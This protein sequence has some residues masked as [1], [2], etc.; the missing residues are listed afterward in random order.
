MKNLV[1]AST[2][3]LL[4]S[5]LVFQVEKRKEEGGQDPPAV[6]LLRSGT[7]LREV[8]GGILSD[9][10]VGECLPAYFVD[11]GCPACRELVAQWDAAGRPRSLWVVA[12]LAPT[13]KEFVTSHGFGKG[14]YHVFD[15]GSGS[16][17]RLASVG[18]HAAP[19]SAVLDT[20]GVLQRLRGGGS[21]V[22]PGV[23]KEYCH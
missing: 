20:Q 1:K 23:L 5:L 6:S 2:V 12:G 13:A 7:P 21:L 22:E 4:L 9:F 3:G 16:V 15:S 17:T 14:E 19:T 18:I 11:P 10:P 8:G